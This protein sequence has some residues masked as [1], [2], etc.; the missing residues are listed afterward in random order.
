RTFQASAKEVWELWTT[1]EGLESW[2]G[3][4]KD[5]PRRS[6]SS[7]S[8]QGRIRICHDGD[9]PGPDRGDEGDGASAHERGAWDVYGGH[10][11]AA[12]RVHDAG[13]LHPGRCTVRGRGV[14][15]DSAS[16]PRS[17]N[18]LDRGCDARRALDR[19]VNDGHEQLAR[20]ARESPRGAPRK[21]TD[22][23]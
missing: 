17:P 14:G 4:P 2:W 21:A 9:P 16:G 8:A 3:P 20:P 18:G 6:T 12:A 10:A 5:S 22:V 11:A 1:K 7:T 19:E 23:A 13:R 15:R